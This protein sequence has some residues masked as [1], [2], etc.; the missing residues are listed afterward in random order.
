MVQKTPTPVPEAL[1]LQI[2]CTIHALCD[3]ALPILS[4][5]LADQ[6]SVH[7]L[8]HL[9]EACAAVQAAEACQRATTP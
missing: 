9:G 5:L 4:G 3:Y 8:H 1:A 7:A 6:T 2:I